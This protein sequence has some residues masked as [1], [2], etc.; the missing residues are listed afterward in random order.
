MANGWAPDGAV[1]DQ[2]DDSVKDALATARAR[3]PSGPGTLACEECGEE[4]PEAR[5]KALPGARTCVACQSARDKRPAFSAINRR[6][7]KDSQLR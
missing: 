4:I 1:Q 2:I 3:M 5:R 7:S 6:G